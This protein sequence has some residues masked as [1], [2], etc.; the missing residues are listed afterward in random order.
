[1]DQEA[2]RHKPDAGNRKAG[3]VDRDGHI[4]VQRMEPD[5]AAVGIIDRRGQQM[6]QIHDHRRTEDHPDFE[7]LFHPKQVHAGQ[8]HDEMQQDMEN[9]PHEVGII[10]RKVAQYFLR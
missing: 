5:A 3:T 4:G 8:G 1:M 7:L 9:W 6:V 2:N 10:S